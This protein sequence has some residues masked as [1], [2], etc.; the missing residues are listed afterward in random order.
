MTTI[1]GCPANAH[2]GDD[3]AEGVDN[4][5][6][7]GLDMDEAGDDPACDAAWTVG[8]NAGTALAARRMRGR[9]KT[10]D[11]ATRREAIVASAHDLFVTHGYGATPMGA[12]AAK[13]RISKQT[14]YRLFPQKVDLFRGVAEA[15][16]GTV[17]ALPRP[18]GEDLPLVEALDQIFMVDLDAEREVERVRFFD[19]VMSESSDYPELN[20]VMHDIG[21]NY[22]VRHMADWLEIQRAAGRL[23]LDDAQGTAMI[24]LDM[25]F[26]PMKPKHARRCLPPDPEWR[27]THMRRAIGIFLNGT[28]TR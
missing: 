8:R 18:A 17:L 12:V 19:M 1:A 9:P 3:V 14:L 28:A 6:P 27:R 10:Q 25:I 11:D 4:D 15:F 5:F 20:D 7:D 21:T 26:G 23:A 13:C 22:I 24:L 16:V 2:A